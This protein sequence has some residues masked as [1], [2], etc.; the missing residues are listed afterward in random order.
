M[1]ILYPLLEF[2][3]GFAAFMVG[4]YALHMAVETLKQ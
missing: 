4:W 3:I 2:A 1:H